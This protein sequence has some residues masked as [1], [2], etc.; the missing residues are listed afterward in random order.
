VRDPRLEIDS[1]QVAAAVGI[2][3]DTGEG[4]QLTDSYGIT[5]TGVPATW[6]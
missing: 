1:A 2:T 4:F 3:A 6:R 5:Y